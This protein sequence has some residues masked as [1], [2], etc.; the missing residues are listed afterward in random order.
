MLAYS[1]RIDVCRSSQVGDFWI[2]R[3]LTNSPEFLYLL[4]NTKAF[5]KVANVS[6]GSKMP[7]ADWNLVSNSDFY[8]P[9]D[10]KEQQA[11][12]NF[13][14]SLDSMI[15]LTSKKIEK[16]K[17]TLTGCMQTMFPQEGELEPKVRFKGFEGDW[18][19]NQIEDLFEIRN[20][21]TPSKNVRDY[22]ENGTIP[23]FELS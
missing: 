18:E 10:V 2:L 7:R 21:Y 16:L 19:K 4:T 15:T 20:G 22:W 12:A 5:D 13:F 9:S 8:I 3:S 11:I 17:Q 23:W 14:K 6:V 1:W